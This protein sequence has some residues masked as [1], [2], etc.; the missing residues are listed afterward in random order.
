MPSRYACTAWRTQ[1]SWES[2]YRDLFSCASA[3]IKRGMERVQCWQARY[4]VPVGVE[5]T[6]ELLQAKL[7]SLDSSVNPHTLRQVL[8]LSLIRFVNG[9]NDLYQDSVV[10]KSIKDTLLA[11]GIPVWICDQR[12]DATH[13]V[14]PCMSLLERAIRFCLEWIESY[15]WKEVYVATTHTSVS[16]HKSRFIDLFRDATHSILNKTSPR[17]FSSYISL[18]RKIGDKETLALSLL[19]ANSL[20]I[21]YQSSAPSVRALPKLHPDNAKLNTFWSRFLS[22][23]D[24]ASSVG[25]ITACLIQIILQRISAAELDNT[26]LL[27]HGVWLRLALQHLIIGARRKKVLSRRNK[28]KL[29]THRSLT[30]L[31]P[32]TLQVNMSNPGIFTYATARALIKRFPS[33]C[34]ER[35]AKNLIRLSRW[36]SLVRSRDLQSLRTLNRELRHIVLTQQNIRSKAEK[37]DRG[38]REVDPRVYLPVNIGECI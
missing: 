18:A 25:S 21:K 29:P 27:Y 38:W 35:K 10:P 31:A 15:Y 36:I 7:A 22:Y 5:V 6:C 4:K 20:R 12:H 13:H 28:K 3:D 16:E 24:T 23:M 30:Q 37:T 17:Y 9:I 32:Y 34:N 11:I 26:S 19:E 2:T 33:I 8:S 1:E 14:M